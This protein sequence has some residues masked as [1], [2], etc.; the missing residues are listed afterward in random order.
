MISK[1][2]ET[3]KNKWLKLDIQHFAEGDENRDTNTGDNPENNTDNTDNKN[4]DNKG[5]NKDDKPEVTFTQE[6]MSKVAATEAKKERDKILKKLGISD[7]ESGKEALKKYNDLTEAQKTEVDK[8][9]DKL[10]KTLK[11]KEAADSEVANLKSQVAAMKADVKPE[12][13]EDVVVLANK[14]VDDDT[15]IDAAIVKVLEKYP[16]F[17]REAATET[18]EEETKGT[19]KKPKFS[20]G[21][22]KDE[23]KPSEQDSW[24]QAFAFGKVTK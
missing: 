11:D 14:Y 3:S 23:A 20:T 16:S 17:K 10:A 15:D 6:Q 21:D 8:A 19:N 5:D 12:S 24:N 22:H 13:V 18:K 4:P 7:I 1:Q 9:N 2:L